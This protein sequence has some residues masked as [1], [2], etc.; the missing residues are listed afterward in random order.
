M[1]SKELDAPTCFVC[2][3]YSKRM[4]LNCPL[5]ICE[6]CNVLLEYKKNRTILYPEIDQIEENL[7]LGNED[8][9]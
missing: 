5:D 4:F 2:G 7:Y 9:A 3:T 8:A 6:G 1:D